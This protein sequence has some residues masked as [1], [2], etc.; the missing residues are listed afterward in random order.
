MNQDEI[1]KITQEM[2]EVVAQ[3]YEDDVE[4]NPAVL[5]EFFDCAACGEHKTL[6]GSISYGNYRL[7]NDCVLYAELGFKLKKFQNVQD[8]IDAM[9][10]KRLETICEFIRMDEIAQG[11]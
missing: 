8:L 1:L 4:E 2:Q 6:A 5:E 10:E 7:C 11:N 9:E 3:M